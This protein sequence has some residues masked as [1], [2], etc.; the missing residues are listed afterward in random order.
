MLAPN[1]RRGRLLKVL[2]E[3]SDNSLLYRELEIERPLALPLLVGG[4]HVRLGIGEGG[5]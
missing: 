1:G 3:A 4:K 5:A 2:K